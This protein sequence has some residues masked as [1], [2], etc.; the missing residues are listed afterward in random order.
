MRMVNKSIISRFKKASVTV[1]GKENNKIPRYQYNLMMS[2]DAILTIKL[3]ANVLKVPQYVI[4]EHI[5]ELG[6]NLLLESTETP[7]QQQKL[8]EHLVNVHLL[9]HEMKDDM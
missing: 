3:L 2:Y 7:E 1:T 5:I 8:K 6:S 4:C 9:G